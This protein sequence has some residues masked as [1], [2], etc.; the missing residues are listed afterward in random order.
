MRISFVYQ[1]KTKIC[2]CQKWSS[3]LQLINIKFDTNSVS[4][5]TQGVGNPLQLAVTAASL[6]TARIQYLCLNPLI[7]PMH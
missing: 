1:G 5:N 7:M 4:S 2:P 3:I 6:S